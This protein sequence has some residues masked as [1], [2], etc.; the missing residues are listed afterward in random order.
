[1]ETFFVALVALGII[2]VARWAYIRMLRRK[3]RTRDRTADLRAHIGLYR[4]FA[5]T[6]ESAVAMGEITMDIDID[7]VD[8][9]HASGRRIDEMS[10]RTSEFVPM[11]EKEIAA[12]FR[13]GSVAVTA[14]VGF[15]L[16]NGGALKILFLPVTDRSRASTVL[17][18][19]GMGEY[20]GPTVFFTPDQVASGAFDQAVDFLDSKFPRKVVPRLAFGGKP[21]SSR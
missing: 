17:R 13:P 6:D 9:R 7:T 2:I 1:M 8:I 4:G 20:L 11:T 5:P 3:F 18:T 12:E 15:R 19:G 16:D 21:P 14:S 10:L